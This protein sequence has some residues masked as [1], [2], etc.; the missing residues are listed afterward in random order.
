MATIQTGIV[1][2]LQRDCLNQGIPVSSILRKAKVIASK[3]DLDELKQ[4]IGWELEGYSCAPDDLPSHRKGVGQ[5]KFLNPY[6]GWCPIMAN[7]D[8]FGKMIRTV[9]MS[10]SIS[11]LEQLSSGDDS[12]GLIMYFN[13]AVQKALQK[14]LPIPME[15][16]L[17]FSKAQVI[18][19]LDYVRNKTLDWTLELENRDIIGQEYTFGEQQKMEAQMVTNHI[20]GSTVGVLGSVSGDANNTGIF[21]VGGNVSVEKVRNIAEQIREALPA[22]PAKIRVDAEKSLV[23]IETEASSESPSKGK[24]SQAI[25]SLK[26]IMEGAGGNLAASAILTALSGI[27]F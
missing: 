9:F 5:P 16:A 17:H 12:A 26:A 1:L 25:E 19:A 7:N 21:N 6:N 20:Y 8:W 14:N 4:W 15:C 18:S 2:E 24:I 27:T 23:T 22:V 10:Q 13:P 11:E 3:L